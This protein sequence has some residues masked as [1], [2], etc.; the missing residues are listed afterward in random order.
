MGLRL[1]IRC[2]IWTSA[3]EKFWTRLVNIWVMI[4][5]HL[6]N[7]WSTAFAASMIHKKFSNFGWIMGV[8]KSVDQTLPKCWPIVTQALTNLVQIFCQ[9][10][11]HI[12]LKNV[13]PY[14][15]FWTMYKMLNP[16]TSDS[17]SDKFLWVFLYLRVTTFQGF[18]MYGNNSMNLR[19]FHKVL[20]FHWILWFLCA[21]LRAK[22]LAKNSSKTKWSCFAINVWDFVILTNFCVEKQ[23]IF[24]HW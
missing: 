19:D 16:P 5:Q 1:W 23:Y 10:Y 8:A 15:Y 18:K 13:N 24:H 7:V 6:G 2:V 21:S 3:S 17:K 12:F 22:K 20:I 9:R 4:G 14:S 11:V